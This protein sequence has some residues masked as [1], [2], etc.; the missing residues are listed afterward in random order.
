MKS[1]VL[2]I[3]SY[4]EYMGANRSLYQLLKEVKENQNYSPLVLLPASGSF[5]EKLT[6]IE[7]PYIISRFCL[8]TYI[9]GNW[10]NQLVGFFRGL[11][12]WIFLIGIMYK[13]RKWKIS[14]VHSNSSVVDIGCYIAFLLRVPHIWHIREFAKEHYS[15]EYNFGDKFAK[16]MYAHGALKIVT[17]S[18]VL[19]DYY[20]P[21]VSPIKL[22]RIYNGIDVSSYLNV[23]RDLSSTKTFQIAVV[24]LLHPSKHPD[25][26][27]YAISDLIN[28][29]AFRNLH[30]NFYGGFQNDNYLTSLEELV[31]AEKLNDYVTFKGYIDDVKEELLSSHIG[32]L[33]SEFEAFGRVTVEYMLSRMI[34]VVTNSG[35]NIE[36]IENG[37][38][39]FVFELN[40]A[41]DLSDKLYYIISNYFSLQRIIENNYKEAIDKYSSKSNCKAIESLYRNVLELR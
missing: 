29:K 28:R 13:L 4:S 21:F 10:G 35:A 1:T 3:P 14:L 16:W 9:R 33:A 23:Y 39:G 6:E 26:V 27:I 31:E 5:C 30:L 12:N 32:V 2:F 22:C 17:I 11:A 7:V 8:C 38:N 40:D 20:K 36:I 15:Y 41:I 34:P 37:K 18:D 25:I 19:L 24:G